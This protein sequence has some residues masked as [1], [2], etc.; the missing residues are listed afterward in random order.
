MT[1]STDQVLT[2]LGPQHFLQ[3][4]SELEILLNKNEREV[5]CLYVY[6]YHIDEDVDGGVDG[7]HQVVALGQNL[8]PGRPEQELAIADHLVC[9]VSIG[10]QLL[11]V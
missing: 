9:L 11:R 6:L 10:N 1:H 7:E 2:I 5:F 8:G 3:S 4:C